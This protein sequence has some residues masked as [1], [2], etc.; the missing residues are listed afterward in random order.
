MF[1][2]VEGQARQIGAQTSRRRGEWP[3]RLTRFCSLSFLEIYL[4]EDAR[5]LA[6]ACWGRRQQAIWV[7]GFTS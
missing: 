1:S 4:V 6:Q 5:S 3:R 7:N 2:F